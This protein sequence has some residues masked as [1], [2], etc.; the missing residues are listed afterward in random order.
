MEGSNLQSA[1]ATPLLLEPQPAQQP[2]QPPQPA[3]GVIALEPWVAP[4]PPASP[5]TPSGPPAVDR[6]RVYSLGSHTPRSVTPGRLSPRPNPAAAA[7]LQIKCCQPTRTGACGM[8]GAAFV[9]YFSL[10]A[11]VA[12]AGYVA[13]V[14]LA[15]LEQ[16]RGCTEP[17]FTCTELWATTKRASEMFS[18]QI[19]QPLRWAAYTVLFVHHSPS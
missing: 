8:Q 19:P 7:R 6:P 11:A 5:G 12:S 2:A 16:N 9:F 15:W 10:I 3:K 18:S 1:L 13:V 4:P 14:W 17:G